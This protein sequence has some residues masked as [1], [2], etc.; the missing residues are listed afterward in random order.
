MRDCLRILIATLALLAGYT[1]LVQFAGWHANYGEANTVINEIKW[2]RY[3]RTPDPQVVMLGSSMGGR[4]PIEVLAGP[5]QRAVSL[6]LDGSGPSLGAALLEEDG[7]WPEVVVIEANT[8]I[9]P[10]SP[11]DLTLR[12][13]FRSFHNVLGRALPIF[14]AE[15]RPVSIVFS[16]LKEWMDERR[17]RGQAPAQSSQADLDQL[18][19]RQGNPTK[20][21]QAATTPEADQW[22]ATARRFQARGCRVVVVMLPDGGRDQ[23]ENYA[24]ARRLAAEGFRFL[25]V[26]GAFREDRFRYTD[27]LHLIRASGWEV[28][29]LIGR[30]IAAS[31]DRG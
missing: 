26:K 21:A 12:S 8:L 24:V 1:G 3:E 2:Q 25:D 11:N 18:L 15:N 16:R 31:A 9:R 19:P 7:V 28:A 17:A 20:P 22:V 23:A 4:L 29:D 14:R 30:A 6:C 5:G 27:G 13:H 10:S